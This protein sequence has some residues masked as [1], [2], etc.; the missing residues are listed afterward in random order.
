MGVGGDDHQ[1][2]RGDLL[3]RERFL[4]PTEPWVSTLIS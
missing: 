2:G 1:V 3:I 4:A